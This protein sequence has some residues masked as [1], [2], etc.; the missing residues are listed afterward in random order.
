MQ[1]AFISFVLF[2]YNIQYLLFTVQVLDFI[3]FMIR[4]FDMTIISKNLLSELVCKK[5]RSSTP[6]KSVLFFARRTGFCDP[7]KPGI[8][9]AHPALCLSRAFFGDCG[10]CDV[11]SQ[12]AGGGEFRRVIDLE[13]KSASSHWG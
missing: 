6:S 3:V 11:L 5:N 1:S 13:N 2:S 8:R 9:Q 7:G 12:Q 10:L 4:C